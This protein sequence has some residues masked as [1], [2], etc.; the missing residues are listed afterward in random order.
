MPRYVPMPGSQRTM[1]PN[2][3]PAGVI[4]RTELASITVRVRS[5]N[6]PAELAR[7]VAEQADRAP[8]E[9]RYLSRAELLAFLRA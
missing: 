9:R 6:D 3:R 2:S 4:D 8:A 1:L 7:W 5:R